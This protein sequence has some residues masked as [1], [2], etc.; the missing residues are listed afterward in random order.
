M[1]DQENSAPAYAGDVGPLEAWDI[2]ESEQSAVLVDCRTD[3]EWSYVGVTDLSSLGKEAAN[4]SWK[5]FPAMALNPGFV[6]RVKAGCP[7]PGAA[8]LFLCRSGVRSIAAA[9]ALAAEG[10]TRCY[11]VA[12][13]FE[14]DA[15]EHK[16]RGGPGGW[17]HRGLPWIQG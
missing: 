12:E 9:T 1:A 8:V 5:I 13:G 14:G 11:N 3:A 6:A 16:H 7:D 2:L 15:D 17:R 4:I 10:Y